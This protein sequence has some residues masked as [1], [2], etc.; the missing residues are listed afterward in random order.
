MCATPVETLCQRCKID[1]RDCLVV[2]LV[3]LTLVCELQRAWFL[4]SI[5]PRGRDTP[6]LS[7]AQLE[8]L[9]DEQVM[10]YLQEGRDRAM[11]S[12]SSSTATRSWS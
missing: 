6:P 12:L 10:A 7:M 1:L 5:N 2:D 4:D 8:R 3:K 11:P 9:S